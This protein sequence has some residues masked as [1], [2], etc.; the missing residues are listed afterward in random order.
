LRERAR[1]RGLYPSLPLWGRDK[2]R[3]LALSPLAGET[4]L[5]SLPLWGRDKVRGTSILSHPHLSP[6]PS[7]ERISGSLSPSPLSSPVE[8]EDKWFSFTLT[9]VLS[10]LAGE[11]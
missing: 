5:L 8:G 6:L 4:T 7:R 10:P 1:V 3:G 11:S 9:L 2:V